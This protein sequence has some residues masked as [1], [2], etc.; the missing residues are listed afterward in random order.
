[1]DQLFKARVSDLVKDLRG[2]RSQAAFGE[3]IGL[4]QSAISDYEKG[5]RLPDNDA[6]ERIAAYCN[7]LPE[8]LMA[9]FYGRAYVEPDPG[10]MISPAAPPTP[11][12]TIDEQIRQMG[13]ADKVRLLSKLS[14]AID[15]DVCG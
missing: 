13:L 1:M 7:L 9:K 8:Q 6:M 11:Q 15:H 2:S 14:Q 3:L 4:S 12:L 10:A 5:K